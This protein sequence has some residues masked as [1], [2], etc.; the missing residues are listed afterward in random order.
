M[1]DFKFAFIDYYSEKPVYQRDNE[2]YLYYYRHKNRGE[3][4]VIQTMGKNG[5]AT[6]QANS[7]R[8]NSSDDVATPDL[9]TKWTTKS[10]D[11]SGWQPEKISVRNT[12]AKNYTDSPTPSPTSM[13]YAAAPDFRP[14]SSPT[15]LSQRYSQAGFGILNKPS[16]TTKIKQAPLPDAGPRDFTWLSNVTQ[17]VGILQNAQKDAISKAQSSKA[18]PE[19][20]CGGQIQM[21][22][23]QECG[24][25]SYADQELE[26]VV[27]SYVAEFAPF[28][29]GNA[30]QP[31]FCFFP[32]ADPLVCFLQ[33]HGK[34]RAFADEAWLRPT[35]SPVSSSPEVPKNASMQG[36]TP[37]LRA[38]AEGLEGGAGA[39]MF[40]QVQQVLR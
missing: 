16:P 12:C 10:E 33:A 29:T 4:G 6:V 15:E 36:G 30:E 32:A 18:T 38:T 5:P 19:E 35:D 39:C 2:T 3:W 28:R 31:T 27:I 20:M 37:W 17:C 21:L 26:W 1:G 9:V 40:G 11:A 24:Q 8:L 22:P 34:G 14:S 25:Q 13:E 23:E 7:S